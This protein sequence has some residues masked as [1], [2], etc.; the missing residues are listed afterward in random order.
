MREHVKLIIVRVALM[1][2]IAKYRAPETPGSQLTPHEAQVGQPDV[3]A[4]QR[5]GIAY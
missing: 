2:F 1:S 4:Q 3:M 5:L